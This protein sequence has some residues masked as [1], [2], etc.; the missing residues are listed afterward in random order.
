MIWLLVATLATYLLPAA[1]PDPSLAQYVMR[2]MLGVIMAFAIWR[3]VRITASV[4]AV[5]AIFEAATS[6][7]G[8]LYSTFTPAFEGMC[9]A[10][11]GLPLTLPVCAFAL[12]AA[13]GIS[14]A[15]K[16]HRGSYGD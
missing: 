6:V 4:F 15:K 10:G 13:A 9:D 8:L 11:T 16:K 12:L 3:G 1:F 5:I 2:G 7:C 14:A